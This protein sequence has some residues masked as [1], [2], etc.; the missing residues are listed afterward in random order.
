L[1]KLEKSNE[2]FAITSITLYD[3]QSFLIE[4]GLDIPPIH[5]LQ[6]YDF[7]KEDAQKAIEMQLKLKGKGKKVYMLDL[8]V[9]ATVMNKGGYLCTLD[10]RLKELEDVGLKLFSV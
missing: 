4:K 6:V 5:L 7:S 10:D 3:V 2:I 9:C 1:E 8:M